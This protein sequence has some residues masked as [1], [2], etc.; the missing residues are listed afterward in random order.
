MRAIVPSRARSLDRA[1][2]PSLVRRFAWVA[3]ALLTSFCG[4]LRGHGSGVEPSISKNILLP[5]LPSPEPLSE[6]VLFSFDRESFPE[7]ENVSID[8][9]QGTNPRRVMPA[10][11][12]D[13]H[14]AHWGCSTIIPIGDLLHLWAMTCT[15][16]AS[17]QYL[18]WA[19]PERDLMSAAHPSCVANGV[20]W[21]KPRRLNVFSSSDF[22]NWTALG[23]GSAR[24]RAS[25]R[26]GG[27]FAPSRCGSMG[28]RR[29]RKRRAGALRSGHLESMG[30]H[31]GVY[32]AW[33]GRERSAFRNPSALGGLSY[34]PV[35]F[36]SS[37]RPVLC[38]YRRILMG[39]LA[40]VSAKRRLFRIAEWLSRS[41]PAPSLIAAWP[42]WES[43]SYMK[44]LSTISMS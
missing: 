6:A 14:D 16:G 30:R 37:T 44:T 33:H 21:E 11:P 20:H 1:T 15:D 29:D 31:P 7:R 28:A 3:A 17:T 24:R 19:P 42:R 4:S 18:C 36:P 25:P 5:S 22:E 43:T 35:V 26:E 27:A 8:L 9:I 32:D 40:P 23:T 34:A 10:G 12:K 39:G 13:S 41:S 2:G 38:S